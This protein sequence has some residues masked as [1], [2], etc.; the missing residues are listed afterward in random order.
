LEEAIDLS[1]DRQILDLDLAIKFLVSFLM[2]FLRN[3][4]DS[5]SSYP[6]PILEQTTDK[7]TFHYRSLKYEA[8]PPSQHSSFIFESHRVMR[9]QRHSA[10]VAVPPRP[11]ASDAAAAAP[12]VARF[13]CTNVTI[14]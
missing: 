14:P 12:A 2:P 8:L 13:Y 4:K 10:A 6:I 9:D 3:I 7:S 11:T 1:G 5:L